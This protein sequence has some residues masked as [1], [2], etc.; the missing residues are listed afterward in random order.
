MKLLCD[1][2]T[3]YGV[4]LSEVEEI[5]EELGDV[6]IAEEESET[7]KKEKSSADEVEEEA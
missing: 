6:V 1:S 4:E 7:G 5:G 3:G 2:E